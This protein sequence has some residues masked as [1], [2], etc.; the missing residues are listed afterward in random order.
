MFV[1]M[2]GNVGL[3]IGEVMD[4]IYYYMCIGSIVGW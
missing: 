2:L 3:Y 1:Y 4:D